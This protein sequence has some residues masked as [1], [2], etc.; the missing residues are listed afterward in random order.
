MSTIT[1]VRKAIAAAVADLADQ[2]SVSAASS[3]YPGDTDRYTLHIIVGKQ[4]DESAERL[5]VLLDTDGEESV[6]ATLETDRTLGGAVSDTFVS[7]HSGYR[8][9][10]SPAG[11]LL[12]AEWTVDVIP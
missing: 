11:A 10:A 9:Y 12:G 5:D 7:K 8:S 2:V 4:G 1:E 3:E 6:K